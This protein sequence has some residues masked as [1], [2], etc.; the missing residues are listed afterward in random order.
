MHFGPSF[1]TPITSNRHMAL[2]IKSSSAARQHESW[3]APATGRNSSGPV[4]Y[5]LRSAG[6]GSVGKLLTFGME[7][8]LI[9]DSEAEDWC[10]VWQMM[11]SE[12]FG[13]GCT[14]CAQHFLLSIMTN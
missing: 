4:S 2:I 9:E 10:T 6:L 14:S 5:N 1:H 12:S 3:P 13:G 11:T 7:V 8:C